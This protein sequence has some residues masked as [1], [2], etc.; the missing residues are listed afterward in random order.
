[1]NNPYS[2]YYIFKPKL[3]NYI[4]HVHRLISLIKKIYKCTTRIQTKNKQRVLFLN[5]YLSDTHDIVQTQKKT[6]KKIHKTSE[7]PCSIDNRWKRHTP[8]ISYRYLGVVC[9]LSLAQ[10]LRA[11]K[12]KKNYRKKSVRTK[13]IVRNK[14]LGGSRRAIRYLIRRTFYCEHAAPIPSVIRP[15]LINVRF[16]GNRFKARR[17]CCLWCI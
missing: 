15:C 2:K 10:L 17:R 14:I 12:K 13:K 16:F 9:V 3:K 11:R 5:Q 6:K 1:M 7:T 8:Q 4:F